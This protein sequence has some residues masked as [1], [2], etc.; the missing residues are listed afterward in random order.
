MIKEAL[1]AITLCVTLVCIGCASPRGE[2]QS[3][4]A[5]GGIGGTG[6]SFGR[7]SETGS[8]LVNE[9]LYALGEAELSIDGAPVDEDAFVVGQI[10]TVLADRVT[11]HERRGAFKVASTNVLIG[12]IDAWVSAEREFIVLGHSVRVDSASIWVGASPGK[13]LP[14]STVRVQGFPDERGGIHATRIEVLGEP[15]GAPLVQIKAQIDVLDERTGTL[16]LGK[17]QVRTEN[18]A[19]SVDPPLTKAQ[20]GAVAI[21]R[22][23]LDKEGILVAQSV[24]IQ[25]NVLDGGML[26]PQVGVGHIEG[27]VN[28]VDRQSFAVGGLRMQ[29]NENL[30]AR[31][32]TR[33]L[34]PGDRVRVVCSWSKGTWTAESLVRLAEQ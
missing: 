8:I 27:V 14:G 20:V 22:G 1:G 2:D 9:A 12:P 15:D 4:R 26:S 21:A 11:G 16:R 31:Q 30:S 17:L 7:I 13:A 10:V 32:V 29:L 3:R 6:I 24:R 18:G 28:A 5:E 19:V 33:S 34:Q 23:R 25:G